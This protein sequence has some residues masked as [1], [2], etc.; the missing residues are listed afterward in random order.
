MISCENKGLSTLFFFFLQQGL[1]DNNIEKEEHL[2]PLQDDGNI[3][4][5]NTPDT[6]LNLQT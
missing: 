2:R 5:I 6:L 4:F 3:T 1:E